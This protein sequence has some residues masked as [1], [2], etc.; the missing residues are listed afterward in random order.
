MGDCHYI[1]SVPERQCK[2]LPNDP[3]PVASACRIAGRASTLKIIG[4]PTILTE[5]SRRPYRQ[6]LSHLHSYLQFI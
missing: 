1:T 2:N 3:S 5:A 6:L 4:T